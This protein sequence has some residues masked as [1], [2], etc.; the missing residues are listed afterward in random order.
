[1]RRAELAAQFQTAYGRPPSPVEALKLAQRATLETRDG[2]HAPRSL[3]E[4]R[5]AWR[6]DALQVLGSPEAL[7]AMV[8]AAQRPVDG[9]ARARSAVDA[10]WV[11]DTAETV[12]AAIASRR[13]TWQ[14]AHVR[15]EAERQVRAADVLLEHV[16]EASSGS[17]PPACHRPGH[18]RWGSPSQSVNRLCCAGRTARRCTAPPAR[19]CT[20]RRQWS[21]LNAR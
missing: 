7:A 4:Q 12:L 17:S 1:V 5:A 10:D 11:A 15:A 18:Y 21:P 19:S 13:A 14:E 3:A 20:P 8:D 9:Q 2:K 6:A 16:S